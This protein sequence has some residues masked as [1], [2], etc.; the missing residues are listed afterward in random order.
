MHYPAILAATEL[1]RLHD[2]LLEGDVGVVEML[3]A[4]LLNTCPSNVHRWLTRV[5]RAVVQDSI[6]CAV[7][8][9]LTN[10]QSFDPTRSGLQSFIERAAFRNVVD[11]LRS[12]RARHTR[13]SVW[14]LERARSSDA[15]TNREGPQTPRDMWPL[16][17]GSCHDLTNRQWAMVES[18][19]Q[20][21]PEGGR[22]RPPRPDRPI[23]D[24]LIG[25]LRHGGW[26]NLPNQDWSSSSSRRY[27]RKWCRAGSLREALDRLEADLSRIRR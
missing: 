5:D 8:S 17:M 15:P 20:P 14:A 4:A 19:F 10:P 1:L 18:L 27:F 7:Q 22:G 9:Y 23:L 11:Q 21:R 13:E 16:L 12:E 24:V 26:Q 3:V 2:R 25:M 6:D